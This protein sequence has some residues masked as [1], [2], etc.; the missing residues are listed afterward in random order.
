MPIYKDYSILDIIAER[1]RHAHIDGKVVLATGEGE[2]NLPLK[3]EAEK[4]QLAFFSGSENDVL[5]RFIDCSSKFGFAKVMR[6][7]CDNPFLDSRLMKNL[8]EQDDIAVD[9]LSYEV[10]GKPAILT[11]YG[12]FAEVISVEALAKI[13]DRTSD[14]LDR[15]H[16][17]R[18][19]YNHPDEFKTKFVSA[20]EAIQKETNI[21]LTVDTKADFENASA[22]LNELMNSRAEFNYSFDDV[23]KA[24]K[25][26]PEL[27]ELMKSQI[28]ENSK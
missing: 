2:R 20:P 12:F 1:I 28:E 25:K 24:V 10:N 18:Y 14:K 17:T 9:Y 11:H 6:I 3:Q 23:L 5:K 16:V 21:R 13:F 7:C 26:N 15:E 22:V 8:I 19:I 27:R 4:N